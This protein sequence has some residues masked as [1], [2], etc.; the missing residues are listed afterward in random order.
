MSSFIVDTTEVSFP[1]EWKE[2]E[3]KQRVGWSVINQQPIG[4]VEVSFQG[5]KMF[6]D[7]KQV[8]V[9]AKPIL[10]KQD[11]THYHDTGMASASENPMFVMMGHLIGSMFERL[12]DVVP[13]MGFISTEKLLAELTN[14]AVIPDAILSFLLENQNDPA[15]R[16]YLTGFLKGSFW[17][18]PAFWGTQYENNAGDKCV[19]ALF[20]LGNEKE[21]ETGEWFWMPVYFHNPQFSFFAPLVVKPDEGKEGS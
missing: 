5:N 17:H 1:K 20:Y 9:Y 21:I 7:G 13:G 2:E 11:Q 19:R 10:E 4:I 6:I 16:G 12:K 14:V 3:V 18:S 8:I 15:V